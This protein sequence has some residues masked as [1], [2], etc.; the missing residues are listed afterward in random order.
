ML[1]G[2]R[3]VG[4]Y[5]PMHELCRSPGSIRS[6]PSGSFWRVP[7]RHIGDTRVGLSMGPWRLH[8]QTLAGRL[9]CPV[10]GGR[11]P[12][13]ALCAS[14]AA[15]TPWL[16]PPESSPLRQRPSPERSRARGGS[17]AFELVATRA[18]EG[19]LSPTPG[20]ATSVLRARPA[21]PNPLLRERT[22]R[23]PRARQSDSPTEPGSTGRAWQRASLTAGLGRLRDRDRAGDELAGKHHHSVVVARTK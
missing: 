13:D 4:T 2:M 10:N 16:Q 5:C 14:N 17:A 20:E 23:R 18:P 12:R 11:R 22:V 6:A 19:A 21:R 1:D 9:A 7:Y 8:V 15:T 3:C